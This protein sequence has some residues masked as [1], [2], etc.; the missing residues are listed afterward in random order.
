MRRE[1]DPD[2][3]AALEE[4][5]DF[6]LA[7]LRDLEREHDAGDIDD[8]DYTDLNDDYTARAAAVLRAIEQRGA[9]ANGVRASQRRSPGRVVAIAVAVAA[10]ALVAGVL[11]A[12]AAGTRTTG[13]S[14]SGDIRQTSRDQLLRAQQ[15]ISEGRLLDAIK[16]YDQIL[17]EQP[18]NREA[19]AYK[20]W[21]LYRVS[22]STADGQLSESD[23]QALRDRALESLS[24]A[25]QVDP[26]YADAHL[27]RAIIYSDSGRS[28]DALADLDQVPQDR[29]PE[30][31]R[32]RVAQLRQKVSAGR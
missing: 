31:L 18:A 14:V 11:V 32:D 21:L 2:A 22:T 9:I 19:L 8:E 28:A 10:A 1:L 16:T 24:Q 4:Q 17:A 26:G 23:L 25:V 3:L 30:F 13:D 7:S 12:Q 27:F 20:G 15:Q 29:V 5:R 6:L